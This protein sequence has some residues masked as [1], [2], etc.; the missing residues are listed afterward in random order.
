MLKK[1]SLL[2]R[3]DRTLRELDPLLPT[4]Q[5]QQDEHPLMRTQDREHPNPLAQRTEAA[6]DAR[7]LVSLL[8]RGSL[9]GLRLNEHLAK[10]ASA[11]SGT[12]ARCP[13]NSAHGT[14]RTSAPCYIG[15]KQP[16]AI[17]ATNSHRL[18]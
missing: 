6:G 8:L 2:N 18:D 1:G 3:L 17:L 15:H 4:Q 5:L 10:I 14:E 9:P 12:P 7:A 16:R 13:A 11:Y